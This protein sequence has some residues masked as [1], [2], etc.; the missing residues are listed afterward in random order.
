M[1]GSLHYQRVSEMPGLVLSDA[2]LSDFQF[3]RHYH[4]D[5]HIGIVTQGFHKQTSRGGSTVLG[6]GSIAVMPPGEMHD[7][8]GLD[9]GT[10]T[11]KTF[12]IPA[13]LLR[14]CIDTVQESFSGGLPGAATIEDSALAQRLM[15]LH[16]QLPGLDALAAQEQWLATLEPLLSRLDVGTPLAVHKGLA[17]RDWKRV[18]DYCHAHIA[19]KISLDQLAKLCDLGKFQFLRRFERATGIT[20]HA[21]L[22]RLRLEQACVLLSSGKSA[23]VDVANSVGFYDQSH[24]NRTFR[25]AY[26]VTPSNY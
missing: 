3:G 19:D 14:S 24:F 12:R 17:T 25:L 23:L 21:W 26:G 7:G 11:L 4:L 20:P 2:Q 15:Q 8:R 18:R 22:I 6:P 1:K 10:Y 13:Q 5:Y 9:N 16:R